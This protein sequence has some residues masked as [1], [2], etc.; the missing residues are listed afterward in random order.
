MTRRPVV[1][2]AAATLAAGDARA[3]EPG[4]TVINSSYGSLT[5]GTILQ[6]LFEARFDAGDGYDTAYDAYANDHFDFIAQRARLILRGSLLTPYLTYMFQGDATLP[7]FLLDAR[8]GFVIPEGEGT[9]TTISVG[10][11]LP[12]FTLILP[13]PPSR[14]DAIEYPLYLFAY[15]DAGG[16][17]QPFADPG[18]LGRQIGLL[19]TQR[20]A[21]IVTIDAG[22]FNGRRREPVHR[23]W[24][25]DNDLKDVMARVAV[26]PVERLLLAVDWWLGL[27]ASLDEAGNP[28]QVST[29][30]GTLENDTAQFLVLEAEWSPVRGLKL[31]GESAF[32]WQTTRSS[33]ADGART[34]ASFSAFG[35]WFHAAYVFEGLLGPGSDVE[36][37]ARYDYF[38]QDTDTGRNTWMRVTLGPHLFLERLHSQVRVNYSISLFDAPYDR[39]AEQRHE[40]AV[41]AT[42]EI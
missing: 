19:A 27:P 10:R 2:L 30:D 16:V 39:W 9:S 13:R 15:H 26:R 6:G 20:I 33:A 8:I 36:L 4:R 3:I 24:E 22:I 18:T 29:T 17:R 25:D 1:L 14:L 41:Q 12:P 23:P 28:F 35:A 40:I 5:V 21:D 31:Q 32:S 38:D 42:V 11:F 7:E 34:S 37:A